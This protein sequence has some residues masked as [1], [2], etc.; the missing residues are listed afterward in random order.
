MANFLPFIAIAFLSILLQGSMSLTNEANNTTVTAMADLASRPKPDTES[1]V[2]DAFEDALAPSAADSPSEAENKEYAFLDLLTEKVFRYTGGGYQ[3]REFRYRLFVPE[4]V[5]G[6]EQFPLVVWLH[7]F[8]EAG[9]D[10]ASQLHYLDKLIF[11]P[12]RRREYFPFFLLA[13]Q[14]PK[15]NP[16]W[17]TDS[18]DADDMLNVALAILNETCDSYHAIDLKRLSVTGISSGGAACWEF[19]AREPNRFAA[20]APISTTGA[21]NIPIERLVKTPIWAFQS[22]RDP[23]APISYVDRIVRALNKAGGSAE[24]TAVNQSPTSKLWVHDAWTEAFKEY[25]L[26]EWLL[27]QRRGERALSPQWHVLQRN[28]VNWNYLWPR[29]IPVAIAAL[30]VAAWR[31]EKRRHRTAQTSSVADSQTEDVP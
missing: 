29:L 23:V 9:N 26:L 10:N 4:G 12:P 14:C 20:L 16:R 28:Y 15:D 19:A 7:G 8:G 27:A 18:A 2:A 30:G 5:D 1:S 17:T 6:R 13:V 11:Q 25:G 31:N 21:S 3:D 24:L 22:Q